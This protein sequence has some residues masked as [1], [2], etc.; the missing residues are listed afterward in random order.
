[1]RFWYTLRIVQ[2]LH[3]QHLEIAGPLSQQRMQHHASQGPAC[4][5]L[6]LGHKILGA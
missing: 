4:S 5:P 1:M 2:S 3:G 6:S